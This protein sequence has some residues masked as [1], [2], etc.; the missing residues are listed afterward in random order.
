VANY[1]I[2]LI[3]WQDMKSNFSFWNMMA[4]EEENNI[5][6]NGIASRLYEAKAL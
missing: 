6:L 2:H 1:S 3:D 5:K 4:R